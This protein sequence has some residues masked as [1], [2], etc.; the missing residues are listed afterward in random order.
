M[1][2][3]IAKS[4]RPQARLCRLYGALTAV[5]LLSLAL[6]PSAFASFGRGLVGAPSD[7]FVTVYGFVLIVFFP[8]LI[9]LLSFIQWRLD[10][11]KE[12]RKAAEKAH[13]GDAHWHGGW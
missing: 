5:A 7:Q 10:R 12:A 2:R 4:L 3:K 8:L 9:G 1:H 13:V 6:A 11:R